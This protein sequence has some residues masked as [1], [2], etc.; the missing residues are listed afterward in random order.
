MTDE[1]IKYKL[2]FPVQKVDIADSYPYPF[3]KEEDGKA[4]ILNPAQIRVSDDELTFSIGQ[5]RS[6][7]PSVMYFKFYGYFYRGST[8]IIE[9]TSPRWVITSE[10]TLKYDTFN[11]KEILDATPQ[12]VL[13]ELGV[14][15]LT[16]EDL[17]HYYFELF[18]LGVSSENPLYMNHIMLAEGTKTEYHQP[19]DAK[20]DVKIGFKNINSVNLYDTTDTFLQ[21]I[22]PYK[23]PM[24]SS[25]LGTSRVTI[26]VPH[27][28]NESEWDNTDNIFYEYMYQTEQRIWIEK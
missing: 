1:I 28:P 21:I 20:Q 7:T 16:V 3:I 8:P 15:K 11:I 23:E 19:N 24:T 18:T 22:R 5:I 25:S 17:D 10:Y 2:T 4:V 6:R 12:P 14:S 27:L 26:L 9:Y 13:D